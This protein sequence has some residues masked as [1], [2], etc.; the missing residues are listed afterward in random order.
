MKTKIQ[1][2]KAVLKK[3]DFATVV[4]VLNYNTGE[5]MEYKVVKVLRGGILVLDTMEIVRPYY[6][7]IVDVY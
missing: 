5:K 7:D 6:P 1:E 2:I 4:E 3:K